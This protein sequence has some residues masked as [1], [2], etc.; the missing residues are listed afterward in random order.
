MIA[1]SE[2][3]RRH[4]NAGAPMSRLRTERLKASLLGGGGPIRMPRVMSVGIDFRR[5]DPLAVLEAQLAKAGVQ[6]PQVLLHRF[7]LPAEP[8]FCRES[9]TMQPPRARDMEPM[10]F[11]RNALV[12][13]LCTPHCYDPSRPLLFTRKSL[14]RRLE[15][16]VDRGYYA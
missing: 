1:Q 2:V 10:E 12:L 4:A 14:L 9:P 5:E 15:L 3:P 13:G 8:C 6:D 16:F 11:L 7:D